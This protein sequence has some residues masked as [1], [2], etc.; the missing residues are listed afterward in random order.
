MKHKTPS[1][2]RN[3]G[4]RE[5]NNKIVSIMHTYSGRIKMGK[6]ELE[7][8][9]LLIMHAKHDI[10]YGEGGTFGDGDKMDEK[11]IEKV[12]K[13]IN[14]LEWILANAIN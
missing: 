10:S 1:L 9:R 13:A 3:A 4:R 6:R 8:M 5:I 14:N 2:A 11:E 12:E 7:N